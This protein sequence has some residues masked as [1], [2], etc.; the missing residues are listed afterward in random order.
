MSKKKLRQ[1]DGSVAQKPSIFQSV[2]AIIAGLVAVKITSYAVTT[3]WRLATREEPPQVDQNVH[4]GKKALWIGLIGAATGAA[5]QTVRDF[6][7]PP[8]EGPA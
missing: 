2:G 3:A 4:W 1:P 6:I 8:T 5:R 7:K